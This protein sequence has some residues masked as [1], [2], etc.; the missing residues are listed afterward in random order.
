VGSSSWNDYFVVAAAQPAQSAAQVHLPARREEVRVFVTLFCKK[1]E[2]KKTRGG[3][4][5]HRGGIFA[6]PVH[7]H[8]S[9]AQAQTV[10][11]ATQAQAQ[12]LPAVRVRGPR[13]GKVSVGGFSL[14][15]PKN[16]G[17]V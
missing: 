5:K 4:D 13:G 16:I 9:A 3:K 8:F 6:P 17:Q 12:E 2:M 11:S 7:G 1:K 15:F 14:G 10:Q